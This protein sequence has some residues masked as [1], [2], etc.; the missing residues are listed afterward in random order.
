M[1]VK[2]SSILFSI[3]LIGLIACT[4]KFLNWVWFRPKRLEKLLRKQG[5]QGNSYR[6]LIGDMKDLISVTKDERPRSIQFSDNLPSH[7]LP[8]YHQICSKYGENSFMWF[9]PSPRL[10]IADPQLMKEIMTRHDLFHKPLP[11]PIGHAVAGGLLFLEDEKWA[12]HRKIINPAFHMEKLKGMV[13]AIRLSCSNMVDKWEALFSSSDKSREID[14]WPSFENLSGDV[15]SRAAFGSSHEEGR[16]IFELQKE[17]VKLVLEL[18][19]FVPTKANKRMRACSKEIKSLLRDIINQ[20]EKAMKRG[21]TIGDDLLGTLMESNIK[22]IHEQGNKKN[23]GMSIE[24]V[25]KECRLFYFAGSETTSL[26]LV[27]MIF[28]EVL[29][30]YP[31]AP[32]L[33]RAPTKTVKLGNITLPVGVDLMLLIGLLHH[34]PKIWGDDVNEF[35]PERFAEGISSATR[36]Q[37]SFVPFGAGPRICIGQHF[38]M[39]EAKLALVMILQRFSFELSPSYLH[40]PFPILTLQ[41]QHGVPLILHK[42]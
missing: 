19:Q 26:L 21:E 37:F 7:I 32:L 15:I 18:M 5:L 4:V 3:L 8:Y 11:D 33:S 17:Q 6:L 27:T 14:V 20:R 28:H 25:I 2:I 34:D 39:I 1:E 13:P 23:V 24:D 29:R 16:R 35:K 12:K 30:M 10:N 9:G 42:L 38:A 31:S 36:G 40:A 41:P 22:E